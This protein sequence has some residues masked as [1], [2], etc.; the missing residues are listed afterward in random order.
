[1]ASAL[2]TTKPRSG[3][4]HY[5]ACSV[6][7]VRFGTQDPSPPPVLMIVSRRLRGV[8]HFSASRA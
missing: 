8:K 7:Q 3:G 1:M 6:V 4:V 5:G 2:P